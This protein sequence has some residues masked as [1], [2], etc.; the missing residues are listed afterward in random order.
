[1]QWPSKSVITLCSRVKE[2]KTLDP[3][4]PKSFLQTPVPTVWSLRKTPSPRSCLCSVHS[5]IGVWIRLRE[6]SSHIWDCS[7]FCGLLCR[8][9]L[10]LR[11]AHCTFPSAES[12]PS[13]TNFL[14]P[15]LSYVPRGEF[16]S[17][18]RFLRRKICCK[19]CSHTCTPLCS[20]SGPVLSC[21]LR[22]GLMI[23]SVLR[24]RTHC[25]LPALELFLVCVHGTA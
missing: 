20:A 11:L 23:V 13:E 25:T 2:G 3:A 15:R 4:F 5:Q 14:F 22:R 21:S 6:P 8:G 9:F 12:N 10:A 19:K 1:M 7:C 18:G 17:C 16:W 24:W